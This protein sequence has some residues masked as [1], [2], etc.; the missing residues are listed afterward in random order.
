L[1][2]A[3]GLAFVHRG[4]IRWRAGHSGFLG[5]RVAAEVIVAGPGATRTARL[6]VLSAALPE[7]KIVPAVA[8]GDRRIRRR[9]GATSVAPV[10]R[11]AKL[12]SQAA[13]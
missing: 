5:E 9:A 6:D 13:A 4:K 3:L 8:F 7:Y 12:Q 1:R 2:E 11:C 10:A